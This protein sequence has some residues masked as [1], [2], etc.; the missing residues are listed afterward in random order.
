MQRE[1]KLP[2]T[3][4]S[5]PWIDAVYRSDVDFGQEICHTG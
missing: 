1:D 4:P 3:E 2:V 5:Q